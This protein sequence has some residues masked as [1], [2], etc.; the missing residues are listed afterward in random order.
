[1]THFLSLILVFGGAALYFMTPAERTRLFQFTLATLRRVKDFV[2]LE[3]LQCDPF[4]DALYA[5]TP[6][7]FATPALLVVS[8][9]TNLFVQS[10]LIDL[11]VTTMCLWQVGVILER[12]VGRVAFITVY[13]AAGVA[14]GIASL[15]VAPG[16][17]NVGASESVL[18]LYGLFLVTSMWSAIRGSNLTIPLN[19]VKRLAPIAAIF[20]LYKLTTTGLGNVAQ[21]AALVC[22]IVGGIVVARDVDER[23][24]QIRR[25]ATAMATVLTVVTLYAMIVVQPPVNETVDVRPEINRVLAVENRTAGL[26]DKEV[27]RFRKGRIN[28]AALADVIEKTIVPELH[29]VAGRLRALRDVPPEQQTLV[30]SAEAFLTL[31]AES[32]QLRAVALHKSDMRGLQ[33]ADTKE[34]AS[35]EAFH[36]LNDARVRHDAETLDAHPPAL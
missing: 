27:E 22:G 29:G 4:L 17:T 33:R 6:R 2:A 25:L 31:R 13:V 16:G 34:R 18:G 28:A 21:L 30:A 8:V 1:V 3:G 10:G 20:V 23:T 36:R 11:L 5:R 32:W 24:P 26:Y 9:V 15:S 19:L 35:R 12:L 14:A 7:A